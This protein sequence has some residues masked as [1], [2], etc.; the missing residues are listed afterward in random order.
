VGWDVGRI[1]LAVLALYPDE[2][3]DAG[4]AT[5]TSLRRC[6]GIELLLARYCIWLMSCS[7]ALGDMDMGRCAGDGVDRGDAWT[8]PACSLSERGLFALAAAAA[9]APLASASAVALAASST[10]PVWWF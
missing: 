5:W 3:V 7:C 9:L 1:P 8:D 10:V 4:L 6:G 2:V